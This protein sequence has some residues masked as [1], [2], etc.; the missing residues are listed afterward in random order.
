MAAYEKS[1]AAIEKRIEHD[2]SDT[3]AMRNLAFVYSAIGLVHADSLKTAAR[4]TRQ[5]H[6][7]S[8]KENYRR[9][10]DTLLKSESLHALS[11]FDRKNLEEV[12]AAIEKLERMR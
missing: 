5:T 11:D 1:C 6:L 3:T 12:R 7:E 2:A 8:A 9:A 4:Q 10:L